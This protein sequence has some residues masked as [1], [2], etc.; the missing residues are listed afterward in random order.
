MRL[1]PCLPPASSGPRLHHCG[2]HVRRHLHHNGGHANR[3]PPAR[4]V[5]CRPGAP[6]LLHAQHEARHAQRVPLHRYDRGGF[7]ALGT[8]SMLGWA[9]GGR[10]MW[11]L[12]PLGLQAPCSTLTCLLLSVITVERHCNAF[13]VPMFVLAIRYPNVYPHSPSTLPSNSILPSLQSVKDKVTNVI[14]F[15]II[16]VAPPN[17]N[18]APPTYYWL[19]VLDQGGYTDSTGKWVPGYWVPNVQGMAVRLYRKNMVV[20]RSVTAARTYL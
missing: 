17:T 15:T 8:K 13:S 4:E 12:L 3:H 5:P 6:G 18:I 19:H 9:C 10:K 7:R 2:K 20:S 14:K 16:A 1:P 11:M